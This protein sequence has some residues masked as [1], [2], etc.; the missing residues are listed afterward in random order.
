MSPEE[1]QNNND[2]DVT[3]QRSEIQIND[4]ENVPGATFSCNSCKKKS[5]NTYRGLNQHLRSCLRKMNDVVTITSSQPVVTLNAPNDTNADER[6]DSNENFQ[7]KNVPGS[8][9]THDLNYIYEHIVYWKKNLF[10]LTSGKAGKMFIREMTR[11]ISAWV[12]DSPLKEISLKALHVMPALLLQ[13]PSKKSKS[14]DHLRALER[15]LNLWVEGELLELFNESL[16]IQERLKPPAVKADISSISKKF[17][18]LMQ[19]GDVN[20]ALRL[21]TNNMSNGILPLNDDTL[22][23]LEQ[24]HPKEGEVRE[25]ALLDQPFERIHSIVYDVIDEDMVLQAA[26]RTKGGSG[27]SGLDADGWRRILCSSTFGT[28]NLDLRKAIAEMTKKLC[29]ESL[30]QNA[31][32]KSPIE[33]FVACRLIPLNKNPGLRPIGVGEVLRRIVGKIVMNISKND[34]IKSVGSLQVCA[35]QI[36]GVEAAIHSMH[37][38]YDLEETEAVLLIDAENAFNLINRKVMLHN[39]SILCPIIATF[40]NNC[41]AVPARLFVIGGKEI[42]S[43][44]GTTQG[45]PTSMAA[46][47]IGVTPL[48]R[49]LYDQTRTQNHTLKEVAFADDFTVAGKISEIKGFWNAIMSSGPKYGYFPKAEKSYLIVKDTHLASANEQFS[50]TEIRVTSTGQ[51]H[52]GAVIG[53]Q[54]FKEDYVN[55]KIDDLVNQLKLLSKIAEIEPQAAYCAFVTGFK[56]KLTF[57]LRT[58]P[59]IQNLLQP[60]E[61]TIRHEFIPAV[62][63]GH[64]CSDNERE[65]LSLPTRFGGL[66]ISIFPE[67]S[68]FEYDYSKSVTKTLVDS[69]V[70]QEFEATY[71][72]DSILKAKS[73][74]RSSRET[75]SKNKL[76]ACRE[77]MSEKHLKINNINQQKG[78]SNWLT[79]LPLS[80]HGFVLNKQ[81]FWDAI[82][83]RY[84]WS[85]ANLPSIC[86]CGAKLDVDHCMN[87]KKGGFVTKRHNVIRDFTAKMLNEVCH[88]VE[89]E[90]A[91]LSLT[92]E[93]YDHKTA[94]TGDECRPDIRARGFWINGQQAFFDV[95][96]FDPSASRYA[97]QTM[98]QCFAKNEK[99]KKRNYND[100]VINVDNGSFTPLIFSIHGGMGRECNTFYSRLSE[101]IANKK[102]APFSITVSWIRTKICFALLSSSLL[103]LRGSRNIYRNFEL[104]DDIAVGH[105]TSKI[106]Q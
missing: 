11:L 37:D 79:V 30:S 101:L 13:K 65:L 77:H 78:V 82:R 50:N 10:L 102:K 68:Q 35:G 95:R 105:A 56:S 62:T 92:G 66:N 104:G 1:I 17:R 32:D 45:D 64:L 42:L 49:L 70:N 73:K 22:L 41:Y 55:R 38:V 53:S 75:R 16:A 81:E 36:S 2:S 3:T 93:S 96:V 8:K 98:Q 43:N 14:K 39:I 97:N 47:A 27:P 24:K 46:Y 21:L 4:A 83:L 9:F 87:C 5:F 94:K 86:A 89:V 103:C 18:L 52:L 106:D 74:V 90:P 7:W 60:L 34:V 44:E 40:V 29:I 51:R 84:G 71:D 15:R 26:T 12:D 19:K 25:E 33:A 76:N 58:I 85:I 23:L 63:G 48:L 28:T 61:H 99:E 57:L 59:N 91:L 88:D 20:G 100:R 80:E 67:E 54:T 6:V 72:Q 31:G 69:I